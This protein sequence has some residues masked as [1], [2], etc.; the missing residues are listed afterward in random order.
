MGTSLKADVG[1]WRRL[2][3]VLQAQ[4][5]TANAHIPFDFQLNS[6]VLVAGDYTFMNSPLLDHETGESP[7]ICKAFSGFERQRTDFPRETDTN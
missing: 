5:Y 2:W 7:A 1:A 4:E 6:K 3:G